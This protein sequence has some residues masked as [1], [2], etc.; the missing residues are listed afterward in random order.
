M[1]RKLLEQTAKRFQGI[2]E[3]K[4]AGKQRLKDSEKL[5]EAKRYRGAMYLAGYSVECK[6]KTR[7]MEEKQVKTLDQLS[8]KLGIDTK[9]HDLTF[10]ASKLSGWSRLFC[11]RYFQQHWGRITNWSV[12]WRYAPE[13]QANFE[14]ERFV[15]SVKEVVSCIDRNL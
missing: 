13:I 10:L 5:F 1:K 4:E 2:S 12:N 14:A 3:Q 15:H 6:L 8:T 11:Q 9:I 7:L